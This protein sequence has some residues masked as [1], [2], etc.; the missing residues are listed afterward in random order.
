MQEPMVFEVLRQPYKRKTETAPTKT[1][2]AS[3]FFNQL[4]KEGDMAI[5]KNMQDL[6]KAKQAINVKVNVHEHAF[7]LPPTEPLRTVVPQTQ[8]KA[9]QEER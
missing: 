9:G 5:K 8:L 4:Q 7:S 2:G 1:S 6:C 3:F